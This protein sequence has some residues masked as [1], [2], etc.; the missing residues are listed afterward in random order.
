MVMG[1]ISG[2]W[3]NAIAFIMMLLIVLIKPQG[4]FGIKI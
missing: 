1:Y 2:S 4:L 3:S